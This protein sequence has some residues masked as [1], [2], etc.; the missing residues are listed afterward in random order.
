M[1]LLGFLFLTNQKTEQDMRKVL[2]L[3]SAIVLKY[4]ILL[5]I[6]NNVFI[7]I[8]KTILYNLLR[9]FTHPHISHFLK[10]YE[11]NVV[12]VYSCPQAP[13]GDWFQDLMQIPKSM[14]A[15]GLQQ[16]ALQDP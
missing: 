3:T 11:E 8:N 9:V 15:L 12:Y 5:R 13:V 7:D 6:Y 10:A 16:L 14:A 1:N 2:V 4:F